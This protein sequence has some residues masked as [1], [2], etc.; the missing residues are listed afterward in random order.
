MSLLC[1]RPCVVK[2]NDRIIRHREPWPGWGQGKANR[3]RGKLEAGFYEGEIPYCRS[4][5]LH[6]SIRGV[7]AIP[8]WL[9][10]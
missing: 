6:G 8:Q 5:A 2:T 9:F 7:N 10:V 3:V 4:L 1:N